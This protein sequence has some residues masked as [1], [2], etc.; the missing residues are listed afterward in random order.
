MRLA[1]ADRGT[2][3]GRTERFER[4]S[5][6]ASCSSADKDVSALPATTAFA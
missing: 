6:M 5:S 4:A 2:V 1:A 3:A